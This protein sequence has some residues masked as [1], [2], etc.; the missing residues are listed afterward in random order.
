M[1]VNDAAALAALECLGHMGRSAGVVVPILAP[2]LLHRDYGRRSAVRATIEKI[3][4]NWQRSDY[5]KALVP[6]LIALLRQRL[7]GWEKW[8]EELLEVI[9]PSALARLRSRR[10]GLLWFWG[11][12]AACLVLALDFSAWNLYTDTP[13]YQYAFGLESL[14]YKN[15][16]AAPHF[17]RAAEK[18]HAMAAN[19][20]GRMY[21]E[22]GLVAAHGRPSTPSRQK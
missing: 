12:L 7:F 17:K 15:S 1:G 10:E 11:C 8:V 14:A 22:G 18:G 5:A 21:D 16:D 19:Q 6:A 20:L 13:E 3:T 4:P 9:D 2:A